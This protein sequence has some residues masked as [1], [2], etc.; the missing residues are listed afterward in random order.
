MAYTA[1]KTRS[2]RPGWSVTFRHPLRKDS[3]GK[4]GLKI[5]RG[6]GTESDLEADRL[7][8][9][10]NELL[11]DDSWWNAARRAEAEGRFDRVVVEA[12]FGELHAGREDPREIRDRAIVLPGSAAGY[13]RVLF[14][15]TTGAGKTSLLRQL[16]GSDPDEDRF[17]STA[18]AKTTIADI[19]VVQA[20][21]PYSAIVTFFTEFQILT[22]I[23]ECVLDAAI[24][25]Y[26][27][28]DRDRVAERFLNHRDQR[29]RLSYILGSWQSQVGGR[30]NVGG[31]E[32]GSDDVEFDDVEF[33]DNHEVD[34]SAEVPAS[35]LPEREL[36]A[37]QTV[38]AAFVERIL[39]LAAG[40][41]EQVAQRLGVI[42]EET[43][44]E[45]QEALEQL[46]EETLEQE[47]IGRE[48]F[49][50]LVQDVLDAVKSRFEKIETGR[51]SYKRSG[52][53]EYWTFETKDRS[54]F[55]REIRWFS[56]NYWPQFGRLLTPLVEGMRVRG[57]LYPAFSQPK[58]VLIDGQGLGHTPDASASVTTH[59]TRRFSEVDLIL[60]V[61]NAKQPMQA[62]SLSALRAIGASGNADKLA[63]AFTHFD[64]ITGANLR[65]FADR[66]SHVMRSVHSAFANLRPI[67]GPSVVRP[68]EQRLEERCFL[69]GSVE[70][71]LARLNPGAAKYM[72]GQLN[73]LIALS[74]RAATS[75]NIAEAR[76]QYETM[77]LSLA[78]R[79]AV[80][81]FH[82]AWSA[83]LGLSLAEGV[84]R[85]HWTRVKALSRR[86]ATETD[87]EYDNLR[88]LADLVA[89]LNESLSWFIQRP[90]G[91]SN[92]GSDEASRQKAIT[93][94]RRHVSRELHE[95]AYK[96]VVQ[97]QLR[98][99]RSAQAYSGPGSGR[100]R[101]RLIHLILDE[102]AP[103]P[104]TVSGGTSREF[105]KEL[106]AILN[107]AVHEIGGKLSDD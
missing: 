18:P 63:I 103:E 88:P 70:R 57:P 93:R 77:L 25:A 3:R 37:N 80:K 42:Q 59:I 81:S 38:L 98:D 64:Q 16:I 107:A 21:G 28:A 97:D 33:T 22:Q 96:R 74:Q 62:A 71:P 102:A 49:H 36:S 31:A 1:S 51:L 46:V 106:R 9:Q 48:E 75:D 53:P 68:I 35:E 29:F 61:D 47:L 85:E 15:G 30:G 44:P 5:R 34:A 91:W 4:P 104:Q 99:W 23:E 90:T 92:E 32:F 52:W 72:T 20:P 56:S 43:P 67:L 58:L 12:F 94:I 66:R 26:S 76:P 17:P 79:D 7:V 10:L 78:V 19:E 39:G 45:D 55:I 101:A 54:E 41:T 95:L 6:L 11:S 84:R 89:A 87:V 27:D 40:A 86:I 24:L 69:L 14:V 82:E 100:S 83:R 2:G 65:T 105:L 60:L 73:Q 8:G 50:E 13:A